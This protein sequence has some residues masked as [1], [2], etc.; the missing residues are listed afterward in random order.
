MYI[1]CCNDFTRCS[2]YTNNSHVCRRV[3]SQCYQNTVKSFN[4]RM[5][6][7]SVTYIHNLTWKNKASTAHAIY[8]D[9]VTLTDKSAWSILHNQW[10]ALHFFQLECGINKTSHPIQ[11][12]HALDLFLSINLYLFLSDAIVNNVTVTPRTQGSWKCLFF[13]NRLA[14]FFSMSFIERISTF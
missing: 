6:W 10:M 5:F 8:N 11:C 13:D 1:I 7:W 3:I 12:S 2:F 9:H 14:D 4:F